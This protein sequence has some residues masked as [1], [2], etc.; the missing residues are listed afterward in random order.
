VPV[1]VPVASFRASRSQRRAWRANEDLRITDRDACFDEEHFRLYY[2]YLGARHKGG[3]MDN[4]T[5]RQYREFLLGGWTQTRMYEF[6]LRGRLVAVAVADRLLD[7]L[8]AVYTFFE[9]SLARRSLGIYCIL[10]E[11][12]H[13]RRS[14]LEW[15]YLG[16]LIAECPSMRYKDAFL[17]QERFIDG[18]WQRWEGRSRAA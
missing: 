16:Y 6:R 4:P 1:R 17:P 11:I 14:G 18:R 10:W 7:G 12:E 3:G 8:S 9:P 13:A 2:R 15:L 5:R